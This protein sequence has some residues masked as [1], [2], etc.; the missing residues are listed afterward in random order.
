MVRFNDKDYIYEKIDDC[1]IILEVSTQDVFLLNVTSD[2][3]INELLEQK[4]IEKI[5]S[6]HWHKNQTT[7]YDTIYEDF[8][9]IKNILFE[10]GILYEY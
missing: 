7:N 3:I 1:S 6:Q 5:I 8:V 10:K 4:S 2:Y 9:D